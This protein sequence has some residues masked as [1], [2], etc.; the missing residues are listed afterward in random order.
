MEKE[1]KEKWVKA[2]ESGNY[3]QCTGRLKR[4]VVVGVDSYCCLGLLCELAEVPL[5]PLGESLDY[6]FL[7]E[8]NDSSYNYIHNKLLGGYEYMKFVELN[9]D[10]RKTFPEIAEYVKANL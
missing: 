1:L 3:K 8:N 7:E 10:L 2:L 4:P 9:D 5:H 6:K